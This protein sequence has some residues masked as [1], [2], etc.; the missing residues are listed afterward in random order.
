VAGF[1]NEGNVCELRILQPSVAALLGDERA[2]AYKENQRVLDEVRE[3]LN[4]VERE[5]RDGVIGRE[6]VA[7]TL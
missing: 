2:Q 3:R 6:L 4:G 1:N 5:V 7:G